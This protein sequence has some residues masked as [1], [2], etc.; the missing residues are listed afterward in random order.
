[1]TS[2]LWAATWQWTSSAKKWGMRAGIAQSRWAPL[3][4]CDHSAKKAPLRNR[5]SNKAFSH[6]GRAVTIKER[7]VVRE[8]KG[9]GRWAARP[10]ELGWLVQFNKWC[11][12]RSKGH[13]WTSVIS[14]IRNWN[15]NFKNT[16]IGS[17][18]EATLWRM[19]Q[20]RVLYLLS[21]DQDIFS[22]LPGWSGQAPD[23]VSAYTQVKMEDAP[24]LLKIPKS[25]CPDIWIRVPKH[26]WPT[27]WSSME[28]PVVPFERNLYG[29]HP[30]GRTIVGEAIWESSFINT[31]GKKFQNLGMPF[32]YRRKR[33]ILVCVCGRYKTGWQ[34]TQH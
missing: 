20:D 26:K 2:L 17:S 11:D 24:T 14:R 29:Y 10:F 31:V 33:I 21:R 9:E 12:C 15:H 5:H 32:R 22:W 3:A 25:E 28:D 13:W 16:K 34:E 1:M 6:H 19:L 23:A 18:S 8:I 4:C 30:S 7:D 27:S